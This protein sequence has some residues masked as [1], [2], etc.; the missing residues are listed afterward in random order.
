MW[1]NW[2]RESAPPS[3]SSGLRSGAVAGDPPGKPTGRWPTPTCGSYRNTVTTAPLGIGDPQCLLATGGPGHAADQRPVSS[4]LS[5]PSSWNRSG[6]VT[7]SAFDTYCIRT[8]NNTAKYMTQRSDSL[9]VAFVVL[10]HDVW[11]LTLPR[12]FCDAPD[13]GGLAETLK[14]QKPLG[15]H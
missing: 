9:P 6:R 14:L 2:W 11:D 3:S 12:H 13:D 10:G 7:V 4:A 15:A 5:E 8:L 1:G